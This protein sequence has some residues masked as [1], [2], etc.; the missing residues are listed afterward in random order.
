MLDVI[1]V[2][3]LN[4]CSFFVSKK[5]KENE[6]KMSLFEQKDKTKPFSLDS[7]FFFQPQRKKKQMNDNKEQKTIVQK[8]IFLIRHGQSTSN[9]SG[10]NSPLATLTIEGVQQCIRLHARLR[11]LFQANSTPSIDHIL[12][13]P[14]T[15]ATQTYDIAFS[16]IPHKQLT[17]LDELREWVR[18][19]SDCDHTIHLW[20][21]FFGV[22]SVRRRV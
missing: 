18:V 13:S 12:V 20:F 10:K 4:N 22:G 6:K 1:V 15:R 16:R 19:E 9:V 11:T 14:L 7:V 2:I 5:K 17:I 8:H 3:D 21:F